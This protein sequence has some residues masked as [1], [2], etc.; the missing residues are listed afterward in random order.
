MPTTAQDIIE[1]AYLR[2][3]GNDPGKLADDPELIAHLNRLYLRFYAL[4]GMARPDLVNT[5]MDIELEGNPAKQVMAPVPIEVLKIHNEDLQQVNLIP[6]TERDK[7]WHLHPCVYRSGAYIISR[8]LGGDPVACDILTLTIQDAPVDLTVLASTLDPRFPV[9]HH[10]LLIDSIALYLDTKDEGRDP[11]EHEKLAKEFALAIGAFATEYDLE[12][13]AL[14]FAHA[15]V[16][17]KKVVSPS[18]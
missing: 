17:R 3:S 13:D 14:Q 11:A 8:A 18:A 7:L 6:A 12:P 4:F 5:T 9:R 10:Q 2:S 15:P 16:K 1:F